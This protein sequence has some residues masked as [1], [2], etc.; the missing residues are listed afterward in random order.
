MIID[1]RIINLKSPKKDDVLYFV[2][3]THKYDSSSE[4][5]M[6]DQEKRKVTLSHIQINKIENNKKF[7]SGSSVTDSRSESDTPTPTILEKKHQT[8]I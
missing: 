4:G 1:W 3:E 5:T 7:E 8:R 2:T 6:S